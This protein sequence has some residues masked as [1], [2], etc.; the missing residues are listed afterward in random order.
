MASILRL[1]GRSGDMYQLA[2]GTEELRQVVTAAMKS[3]EVLSFEVGATVLIVN[4]S[5]VESCVVEPQTAPPMTRT[6]TIRRRR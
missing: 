2:V 6:M 5:C 1:G 3:G 4:F